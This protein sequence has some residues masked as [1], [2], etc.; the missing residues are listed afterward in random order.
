MRIGSGLTLPPEHDVE[1]GEDQDEFSLR[2]P[3]DVFGE[4]ISVDG[5]HLGDV[6][7]GV[8]REARATRRKRNVAGG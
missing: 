5:H 4:K 6:R 8:L 7:Y 3:A 2:D 1:A